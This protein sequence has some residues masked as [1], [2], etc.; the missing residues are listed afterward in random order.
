MKRVTR[1]TAIIVLAV[2]AISIMAATGCAG[3]QRKDTD[4]MPEDAVAKMKQAQA[5]AYKKAGPR[6][7]QGRGN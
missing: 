2:L 1:A 5:E 6:A 4:K 3:K 7:P